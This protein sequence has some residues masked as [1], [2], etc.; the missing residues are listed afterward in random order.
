MAYDFG[1]ENLDVFRLSVEVARWMRRSRWPAGM[2]HL[3]DQGTRAADSIVLNIAEAYGR[4]G[5]AGQNHLRIARGSAAEALAV[6]YVA[7][8]TGFQKQKG[9]LLR[10]GNMLEHLRLPPK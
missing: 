5:N 6:L 7:E 1:F 3:K 8:L 10:I 2:A 9:H 4:S